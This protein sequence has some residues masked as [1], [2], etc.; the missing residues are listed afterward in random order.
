LLWNTIDYR[1]LT[2]PNLHQSESGQ[3]DHSFGTSILVRDLA[4]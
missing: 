4:G 3:S 1:S 2:G